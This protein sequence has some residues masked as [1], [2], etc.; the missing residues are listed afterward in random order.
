[1]SA[2]VALNI[3]SEEVCRHTAAQ[4]ARDGIDGI[5]DLAWQAA[6]SL[7][8]EQRDDWCR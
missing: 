4:F 6:L 5:I 7:I 8:E 3:P 1:M 2:G